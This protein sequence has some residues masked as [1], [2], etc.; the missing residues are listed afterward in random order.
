MAQGT[1]LPNGIYQAT[2]LGIESLDRNTPTST[3]KL[4]W[5]WKFE[6]STGPYSGEIVTRISTRNLSPTNSCGKLI[7]QLTT[8]VDGSPSPLNDFCG[9]FYEGSRVRLLIHDCAL[10]EVMP[11]RIIRVRVWG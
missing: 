1:T 9:V 7:T 5:I 3:K 10:W 8:A 2:F 4:F 6:V 11:P